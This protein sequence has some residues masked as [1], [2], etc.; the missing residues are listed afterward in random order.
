MN[1]A[2]F[3]SEGENPIAMTRGLTFLLA[4]ACGAIVA[5]LYYSQTL[6]AS[7]SNDLH[8]NLKLSGFIVTL[9]QF[10][11]GAGLLFIAPL[12]DLIENRRLIIVLLALTFLSLLGMIFLETPLLFLLFCFLLGLTS[13]AAQVIIPFVAHITP[14]EKRGQVVG[15]VMSG[16]LLGIMLSRPMASFFTHFF[17]WRAIFIFSAAFMVLLM[18]LLHRFFPTRK[19]EHNLSY[20]KLIASFPFIFKSYP[21]LRRRAIYQAMLFCVFN[22][23]WT[24]VAV[25]LMGPFFN[26]TQETVAWFAFVGATGALTAP[27]AGRLADR[28]YTKIATG[29]AIFLAVLACLIASWHHGHSLMA[30]VI[31]ALILDIGVACNLILGQ[32]SIYA[33]APEIRGRL[34]GLYVAIFFVGGGIGSALSAYLYRLG[35]WNFIIYAGC[36]VSLLVFCYFIVECL[37]NKK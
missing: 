13:A 1:T 12:S 8:L 2:P 21:V 14:I 17:S 18:I 7:I 27:I 23:F 3:S 24:S 15:N 20:A 34:N 33:L 37:Q 11:Y 25:L 29:I 30:L 26:Y 35:G 4:L 6:I 22:L 19:P 16:L 10:G 9:T 32:R 36:T 28:G 31:A 5:N